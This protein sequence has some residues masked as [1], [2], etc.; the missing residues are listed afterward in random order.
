MATASRPFN[1]FYGMSSSPI[2]AGDNVVLNCDQVTGSFL[3][4]VDRDD[5]RDRWRVERPEVEES[6]TTPIVYTPKEGPS[7]VIVLGSSRLDAYSA[8]SGEQRWWSV[9]TGVA[10]SCSPIV[11]GNELFASVPDHAE[12]LPPPFGHYLDAYDSD[13]DGR[14]SFD[15]VRGK[16]AITAIESMRGPD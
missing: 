8:Q 11:H 12:E 4:A 5:G 1:N 7:E 9:R 13:Q 15:E 16:E 10:P 6:W 3:I 2:L 14:L